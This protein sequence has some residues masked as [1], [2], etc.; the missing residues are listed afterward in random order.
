M[1]F[2]FKDVNFNEN[3]ILSFSLNKIYGIGLSR[4]NYIRSTVGLSYNCK[5]S[6]INEYLYFL[7]TFL[8]KEYYGTDVYLKRMRENKLKDF[9]A[10]KSY[11]SI[12]FSAG[13]PIRGQR[14]HTNAKTMKVLK[15][16]SRKTI[17]YK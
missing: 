6:Y 4:A 11:K 14:T 13:L 8:L 16:S 5:F 15:F 10:F 7:I 12:R 17:S 1:L 9:L 3:Q 2:T